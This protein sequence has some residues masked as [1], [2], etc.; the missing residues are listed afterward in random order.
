MTSVAAA[1]ATAIEHFVILSGAYATSDLV[2]EFGRLPPAMLPAGD[3]KLYQH[4]VALAKSI[5]AQAITLSLPSDFDLP[6][7][8][9]DRLRAAGVRVVRVPGT[10]DLASSLYFVLEVIDAKGGV[11]L[12]HGDTLIQGTC[13]E[14]TDVFFVDEVTD[15]YDWGRVV[16][17]G[18]SPEIVSG[19]TEGGFSREVVCGYFTFS[20]SARLRNILSTG[21]RF[22]G[23]L[24]KYAEETP[25]QIEKI[26]EWLDF[27]HAHLY[28]RA[29]RNMLITRAFNT[30]RYEDERLIK[31]SNNGAKLR[32]ETHWYRNV[33]DAMRLYLPQYLG[34]RVVNRG[35]TDAYEY[36]LEYLY[37]PSLS[38]LAVYGDLP[39]YRWRSILSLCLRFLDKSRRISSSKNDPA[40]NPDVCRAHFDF[41]VR[42]KTLDRLNVFARETGFDLDAPL[43]INGAAAPST[44]E[45]ARRAIAAI[46]P[47]TPEDIRFWHGDFFFGNI[48]YDARSSCLKVVDP[49]GESLPGML[50]VFGDVRYDRAKL[51]HSLIGRYDHIV[52]KRIS[53][54]RQAHTRFV[55]EFPPHFLG[56]TAMDVVAT[57]QVGDQPLMTRETLALTVLLFLSMLPLHGEAP[58][59]QMAML[60]NAARLYLMLDDLEI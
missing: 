7:L 12:L 10:L 35:G 6:E 39:S 19:F 22:L 36:D 5:G 11:A 46:A 2:A 54:T 29:R 9:A 32:A 33:P 49:R 44:A 16:R 53:F 37:I 3:A 30:I 17:G 14:Q 47:T 55:L 4:Q 21:K 41:L 58:E 1:D 60:A 20:D 38:D 40:W 26:S 50:S 52:A 27:G 31:T 15:Y 25:V 57:A 56:D 34:E 48:L 42:D 8:D 23:A 45:I 43:E 28:Y 13:L 18:A 24:N 51:L 59:R